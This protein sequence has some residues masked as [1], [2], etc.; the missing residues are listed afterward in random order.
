MLPD[1]ERPSS[2][3]LTGTPDRVELRRALRQADVS[4]YPTEIYLVGVDGPMEDR[5]VADGTT[6]LWEEEG[7]WF[8]DSS[9][10]G[11]VDRWYAFVFDSEAVACRWLYDRLYLWRYGDAARVYLRY[12]EDVGDHQAVEETSRHV[13]AIARVSKRL[14]EHSRLIPT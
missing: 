9:E 2:R 6:V 4:W 3:H 12:L 11:Q 7:R 1:L 14:E 8:V 10:R 5:P 13:D